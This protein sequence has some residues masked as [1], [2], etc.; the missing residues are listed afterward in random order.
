[1]LLATWMGYPAALALAKK[2]TNKATVKARQRR[3][4]CYD[5][6]TR[7]SIIVSAFNEEAKVLD[8]IDN[9]LSVVNKYKNVEVIIVSDNSTDGTFQIVDA[10]KDDRVRVYENQRGKG[11]ASAHNFAMEVATGEIVFFTDAE[12]QF[13][14]NY[15]DII[16]DKFSADSEIGFVVAQ[17]DYYDST[18]VVSKGAGFYWKFELWLRNLESELGLLCTGTGACCAVKREHFVSIS[19]IGDV[20][21]VTPLDVVMQGARCVYEKKAIARDNS[22]E[23]ASAEF[24]MRVRQVAKNFKGTLSRWRAEFYWRRP[25]ITLALFFHKIFRWLT[26]VFVILSLVCSIVLSFHNNSYLV[27]VLLTILFSS[28]SGLG[29]LSQHYEFGWR[30]AEGAYAFFVVNLAFLKGLFLVATDNV[31]KSYLPM[32]SYGR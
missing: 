13:M 1:M 8:R 17:L 24:S 21:F 31:P 27:F 15:L 16:L 9:I 14:P 25:T 10:C 32:R 6:S 20:D 12:T 4:N 29:R 2:I 26:P 22:P 23:T 7:Y 30:Y 28:F 3:K 5:E 11:R 18:N 19:D